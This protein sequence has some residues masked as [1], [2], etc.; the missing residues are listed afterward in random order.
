MAEAGRLRSGSGAGRAQDAAA[1]DSQKLDA[2]LA[3]V[4]SIGNSLERARTSLEAKIDKL[5]SDLILLHADHR[6][7]ADKTGPCNL[8]G[9]AIPFAPA[10]SLLGTSRGSIV[11][12]GSELRAWHAAELYTLGDLY[13]DDWKVVPCIRN[14]YRV[15]VARLP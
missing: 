9:G 4:E 6:N 8:L 14:L 1:Q 5:A 15:D 11:T 7:L 3:A 2:V 12:S 13:V 10:L